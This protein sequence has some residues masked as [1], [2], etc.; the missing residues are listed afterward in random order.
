MRYLRPLVS[1]R[2]ESL[3]NIAKLYKNNLLKSPLDFYQLHYKK[4]QLLK[5]EGFQE[6]TVNNI[7]N[8]I[9]NSKKKPFANL[10]SALGIPLL[11]SVKTKKLTIFYPN[12]TNFLAAI[13]NNEWDK[14]REIL[15]EETQKEMRN[16]FQKSENKKLVEKL[17]EI[18]KN[19]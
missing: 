17:K 11:S 2:N 7:L 8:S 18:W 9:E 16:Y 1:F 13:E 4:E 5:L 3:K 12:L 14:I 15:G 10:L 19:T 6:K